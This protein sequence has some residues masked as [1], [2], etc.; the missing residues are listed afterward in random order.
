MHT[1][2]YLARFIIEAETPLFVG[3]GQASLLKDALVQK[4]CNG[5]PMINGTSLAGVLRNALASNEWIDSIFGF[6]NGD[7]G[8]GSLLKVSSAYMLLNES[9]VSEGIAEYRDDKLIN[10][11]NNLPSRQHVRINHKGVAAEKGLFDNEVVYKGVRFVFELELRG[12]KNDET[13]W[14]SIVNQTQSPNFRIGSGTRNGYG[15]LKVLKLYNKTFDLTQKSDFDAYLNFNPSFNAKLDWK[16]VRSE[17][18]TNDAFTQYSFILKPDL[19][20]VFSEGFGDDEADNR[21]LE[22]EVAIYRNNTIEFDKQTIIPASSIKGAISHRVAFHYNRI[23]E[24]FA[25]YDKGKTGIDND[26]VVALFGKAGKDNDSKVVD[27]QAG[28]VFI[29][30]FYFMDK[31]ISNKKIFNHVAI[32][33][34]TGGA[35]AGALFSEKVSSIGT[36]NFNFDVFVKLSDTIDANIVNAFEAALTDICKGL[37]P[38]GG[39]TTKGHGMFTGSVLRNGTK[40]YNYDNK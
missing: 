31:Q 34:F 33:R 10:K 21:P 13:S 2:R 7:K 26:A 9:D 12:T 18:I 3:S 20:F 6:A 8:N 27:A 17:L 32:D 14:N 5:F 36:G 25:D 11:F 23:T 4:D 39:M 22:E 29:N 16:E 1:H 40:L 38:L 35:M 15:S 24:Q 19:F 28:N 37:L 30:D